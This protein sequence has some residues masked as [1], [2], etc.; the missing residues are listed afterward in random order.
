MIRTAI[1]GGTGYGAMELLRLSLAH[2]ELEVVALS[3]RSQDG[4]VAER[5]AH[6]RGLVDLEFCALPAVELA[7]DAELVVFATPHGVAAEQAAGVL[8]AHPHVRVLDLSGDH[9][10][11][12]PAL[13]PEHYGFTHPNPQ[14]LEQAAYGL[15]ECSGAEAVGAARLVANAGCHATATLLATWPLVR[16]GLATGRLAVSSVTGSTGSGGA[17]KA[18]THHPERFGDFAAYRPL[19]HQHQAEVD[20]ALDAVAPDGR[21]PLDFVPHSAPLARGIHVT[22]LV[23]VAAGAE[24]DALAALHEAWSGWPMLRVLD[25]PPRVR[26]VAGSAFADVHAS[27]GDG[28][29]CVCVAIDNLGKGMAGSAVQ[30]VNHMFGLTERTGLLAPSLGP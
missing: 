3:S 20:Q 4:P 7:A 1:V 18:G 12:D 15:V 25:A 26:A 10:L 5:F 2:P 23:P 24:D 16:A 14:V 11:R 27:A 13:Y 28:V 17:P 30:N 29:V 22:A 8:E 21:P 9:R 19:R 6:L